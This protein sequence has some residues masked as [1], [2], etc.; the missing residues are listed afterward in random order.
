VGCPGW[1]RIRVPVRAPAQK[2][3]PVSAQKFAD[4]QRHAP[5]SGGSW[6]R[7]TF[8]LPHLTYLNSQHLNAHM[9]MLG[10]KIRVTLFI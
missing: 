5:A 6:T 3:R 2:W 10:F 1:Q 8:A 7:I 4:L 9:N